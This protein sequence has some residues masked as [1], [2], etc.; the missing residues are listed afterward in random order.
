MGPGGFGENFT[1]EELT[2][3][4]VSIGDIYSIG[5]AHIQVTGPRYPAPKLSTA[6]ASPV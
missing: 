1:V 2:E 6:G 3:Q 5:D 4:T